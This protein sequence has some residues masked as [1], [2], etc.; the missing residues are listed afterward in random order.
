MHFELSLSPM[1]DRNVQTPEVAVA[2][3]KKIHKMDHKAET[4]ALDMSQLTVHRQKNPLIV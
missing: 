1:N 4:K 3:A 2:E